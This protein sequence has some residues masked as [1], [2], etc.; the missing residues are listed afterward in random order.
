MATFRAMNTEVEVLD[1][2]EAPVEALFLDWHRCLSRFDQASELSALN[3]S[4]GR[5]FEASPLLCDVAAR[6]LHWA[7][8]TELFD[9]TIVDALERAGY[10]RSFELVVNHPRGGRLA[11]APRLPGWRGIRLEAGRIL[12]PEGVRLDLGGIAKGTAVDAALVPHPEGMVNAG[13]DLYAKGREYIVGV[14]DPYHTNR[15]ICSLRVCNRGVATSSTWKRRWSA[16][17]HHLIDPRTGAPSQTDVLSATVVAAS[18]EEAE[19]GAKVALLRGLT[20][21]REW[22]ERRGLAGLL[23]GREGTLL[24]SEGFEAYVAAG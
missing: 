21:G 12:L 10:D 1:M 13:G 4:A 20:A 5:W 16:G 23:V 15:D 3:R 9:P 19:V 6:A 18:A 22:L 14:E 2:P 7:A 11:V 17:A 8:Q 24:A